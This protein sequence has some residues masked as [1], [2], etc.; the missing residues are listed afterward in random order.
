[1]YVHGYGSDGN[2]TKGQLLRRM[3]PESRVLSPTFDYDRLTPWQIQDQIRAMVENE[4][5]EMLVGSSFGGYHS[6]CATKF[7]HGTVWAVN[8]VHDI[9]ATLRSAI[10]SR[11]RDEVEGKIFFDMY[12]DFDRQVF[13]SQ[14]ELNREGRWPSDTVL[15]FALSTDDELL[16]DHT[17]LLDLF[18]LHGR[19]EWKEHSGHH[20]LR[21]SELEL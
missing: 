3:L 17:Q 15:N 1:M 19:V 8:P 5:V 18:P 21:F 16:G 20:F 14:S 4:G 2:A 6:L 7:F 10:L 12:I 13:Q 11:V 9:A